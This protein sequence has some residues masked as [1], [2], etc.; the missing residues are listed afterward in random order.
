MHS[1]HLVARRSESATL[2]ERRRPTIPSRSTTPPAPESSTPNVP[3]PAATTR[4]TTALHDSLHY[5]FFIARH[6]LCQFLD[7]PLLA[8]HDTVPPPVVEQ[9]VAQE[10][11][12]SVIRGV[13]QPR[14][15][16]EEGWE[17]W[18]GLFETVDSLTAKAREHNESEARALWSSRVGRSWKDGDAG[19]TVDVEL[20]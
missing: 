16:R 19:E 2:F 4:A 11:V 9:A 6:H 13:A 17:D 7:A 8:W 20:E 10:A 3:L 18:E 12:S 15:S 1:F 5:L 14:L